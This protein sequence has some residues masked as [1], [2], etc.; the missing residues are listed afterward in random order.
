MR[1]A[2]GELVS[3]IAKP[4]AVGILIAGIITFFSRRI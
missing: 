4:F 2:F 1:Y 3:D